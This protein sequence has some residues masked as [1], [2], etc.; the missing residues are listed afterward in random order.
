MLENQNRT[1]NA[2]PKVFQIVLLHTSKENE[3]RKS[4]D[5]NLKGN[6]EYKK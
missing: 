6:N 2:I 1:S 4:G 3:E 5:R